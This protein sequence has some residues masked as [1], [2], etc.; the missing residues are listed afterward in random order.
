MK[1]KLALFSLAASLLAAA[2]STAYALPQYA[3]TFY[4]YSDASYTTI[5]GEGHRDCRNNLHM[6]WGQ[7]TRYLVPRDEEPCPI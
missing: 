3:Y 5:V 4:F 7:Q 1:R 2:A 6:Y